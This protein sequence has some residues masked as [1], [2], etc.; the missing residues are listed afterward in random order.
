MTSVLNIKTKKNAKRWVLL[1]LLTHRERG[2]LM[3]IRGHILHGAEGVTQ[4]KNKPQ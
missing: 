3:K 4:Y 2:T 1:E